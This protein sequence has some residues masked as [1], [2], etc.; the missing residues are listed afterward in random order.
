MAGEKL[1]AELADWWPLLSAP[2]DYAEEAE[3]SFALLSAY[4]AGPVETILELGS[5]GGNNAFHLKGR[6][7]MTLVDLSARMLEVSRRLNPE[8]E[9]VEADMRTVRLGRVFDAVCI[10]DAIM[11]MLDLDDLAGAVTSAAV[12]CRPGGVALFAP[13][14]TV[15]SFTPST[16]HGG[17]D[18]SARWMRYVEWVHPANGRTFVT[19]FAYLLR[20]PQGA[21]EVAL[22][23]HVNGLFT[24]AEWLEAL[25]GAGFSA[26]EERAPD[27][28]D[29]FVGVRVG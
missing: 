5:G 12:H 23:R 13:D 4:P 26:R 3:R 6:A 20:S 7:R 17:H 28:R 25:G 21:V 16:S 29:R 27:G 8:C 15:E 11:Y 18:S 1:Y 10:H 2:D 14:F 19:D 24:R 22:D 9:H